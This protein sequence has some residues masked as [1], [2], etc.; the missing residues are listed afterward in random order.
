MSVRAASGNRLLDLLSDQAF[1]RLESRLVPVSHKFDEPIYEARQEV[2]YVYFP[3]TAVAS[4]L[5]IME[6]GSAI[7]VATVG[8]EGLVGHVIV[9]H[10]ISIN[11]VIIQIAGT[12]LR[13]PASALLAALNEIDEIRYVLVQYRRAYDFQVSRAVACNGLH[14]VEQRCC[15]WLLM[16]RDRVASDEFALTHEYLGMMLG[17]RRS[18]VTEVLAPLQAE[19]LL[20]STR[21]SIS[22]LDRAAIEARACECYDAVNAEYRRLLVR[23]GEENRQRASTL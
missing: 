7:E 13:M 11:R 15:R 8:R 14:K 10:K 19:G 1:A 4:L 3:T 16:T 17:V 18:S 6:D 20:Q 9:D 12:S 22:V 5:T 2:D 21:G 23:F